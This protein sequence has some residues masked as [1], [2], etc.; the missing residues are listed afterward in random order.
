MDET[1]TPVLRRK[2]K[3]RALITCAAKGALITLML[4]CGVALLCSAVA[5]KNDNPGAWVTP[6]AYL[7]ALVS[8]FGGGFTA[9]RLRGRQGL[10]CGL[11]TGIGV[12]LLFAVG[13]LIFAGENEL[14]AGKI[15]LSYLLL[16]AV[17][18]FGGMAGGA[19][20]TK[21]RRRRRH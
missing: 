10:F 3:E 8:V 6:L 1:M 5:Y 16:Y 7:S 18:V 17:T 4:L 2:K 9:A 12:L 19:R 21:P 20:V 11:L 13:L 15:L 14:Q